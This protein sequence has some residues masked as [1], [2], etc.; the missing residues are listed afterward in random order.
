MD[1]TD[2][3]MKRIE[4]GH[5]DM[6]GHDHEIIRA[7]QKWAIA[8]DHTSFEM[9]WITTRTDQLICIAETTG[10]KIYT[11]ESEVGAQGFAKA[12]V[13]SLK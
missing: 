6:W 4:G 8:D 2:A 7:E 12:L 9:R 1:W 10:F 5:Q 11:K 3:Q 13:L